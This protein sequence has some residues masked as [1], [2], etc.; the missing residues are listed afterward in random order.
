MNI[1]LDHYCERIDVGLWGEPFNAI[2]NIGFFIAFFLLFQK[3]THTEK[4]PPFD[5]RVL[6]HLILLIG[7]GS[8]FWHIQTTP[9][10]LWAD[11][12]PILLFINI[13][14]ISCLYR[15]LNCSMR[16]IIYIF[17]LYHVVGT[18]IM[19]IFPIEALNRSIF[20]LPTWLFLAT[21][22]A[23]IYI[24]NGKSD[25]LFLLTLFLFSIAIIF[26]SIDMLACES[27][28]MGTHFLWHLLIS[29]SLYFSVIA[30]IPKQHHDQ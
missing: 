3:N 9:V 17:V 11:R 27:V 19:L 26:R 4:R 23:S 21:V 15:I 25:N 8:T 18:I 16:N 22:T 20:Y 7:L 6:I 5:I 29:I 14:I 1:Y 28:P 30:L 24:K 12:I 2:S 10:S 13:Y